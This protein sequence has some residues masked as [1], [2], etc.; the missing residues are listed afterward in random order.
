MKHV[1]LPYWSQHLIYSLHALIVVTH[2]PSLAITQFEKQFERPVPELD[3]FAAK[4]MRL[5]RALG[6]QVTASNSTL[7]VDMRE[8]RLNHGHNKFVVCFTKHAMSGSSANLIVTIF[9]KHRRDQIESP[10]HS[11]YMCRRPFIV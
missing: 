9:L 5:Y 6:D 2:P 3:Q 10:P 7:A 4:L 11:M 8:I 1:T